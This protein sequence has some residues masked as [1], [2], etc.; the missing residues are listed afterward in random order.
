[1]CPEPVETALPSCPR[2]EGEDGW[3]GCAEATEGQPGELQRPQARC[4]GFSIKFYEPD[5]EFGAGVE[6]GRGLT[7]GTF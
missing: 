5:L 4:A 1:M 7:P 2:Q 3:A 6:Q